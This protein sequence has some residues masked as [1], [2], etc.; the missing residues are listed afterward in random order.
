MTNSCPLKFCRPRIVKTHIPDQAKRMHLW[1]RSDTISA[2]AVVI[3]ICASVIA[4]YAEL[5]VRQSDR[6]GV[7]AVAVAVSNKV[8]TIAQDSEFTGKFLQGF[9][10]HAK[11]YS[12]DAA[13]M[14]FLT[15]DLLS[16]ELPELSVSPEQLTLLA[17]ADSDAASKL[18][19]CAERHANV[20]ADVKKLALAN[21]GKLTYEQR[22]TINVLPFRMRE[23]SEA[24]SASLNALILLVPEL[25]SIMGPIRGTIGEVMDA[26]T[27]AEKAKAAGT[28][29]MLEFRR[30][31]SI[32]KRQEPTRNIK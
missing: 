20:Q 14:D 7:E 31:K 21:L 5:R 26:Q 1:G 11:Q 32:A 17:H 13:H 8:R 18:A 22:L 4:I 15:L 24:C 10:N 27:A 2:V 12:K 9:N 25:P 19:N 6:R 28:D 29:M 23:L 16:T 30:D 3:A